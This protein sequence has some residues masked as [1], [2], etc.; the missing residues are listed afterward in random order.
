[1]YVRRWSDNRK[2]ISLPQ[3]LAE[4]KN[5]A[6]GVGGQHVPDS[7]SG[8]PGS[9]ASN[10]SSQSSQ[11]SDPHG[12]QYLIVSILITIGYRSK[13]GQGLQAPAR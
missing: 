11:T 5:A 12:W 10:S 6:A 4:I 7:M 3:M 8:F 2:D 1:M 13:T 9:P